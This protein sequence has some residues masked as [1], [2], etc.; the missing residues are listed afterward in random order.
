VGNHDPYSDLRPEAAVG[1]GAGMGAGTGTDFTA[2]VQRTLR[3]QAPAWSRRSRRC[4]S[5]PSYG[6]GTLSPG[7]TLAQFTVGTPREQQ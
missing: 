4:F 3:V 6:K 7:N 1:H 5:V 2:E